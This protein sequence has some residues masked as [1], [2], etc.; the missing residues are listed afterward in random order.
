ML[1]TL[2]GMSMEAISLALM[3]AEFPMLVAPAGITTLLVQS[4]PAETTPPV[5]V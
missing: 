2:A 5:I 1:L 4:L 3:N